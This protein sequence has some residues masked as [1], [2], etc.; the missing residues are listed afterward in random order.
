MR[1]RLFAGAFAAAGLAAVLWGCG[2]SSSSPAPSPSPNPTPAPSPAPSGPT[3]TVNIVA[4]TGS[5]AYQ[6]N[7][8]QASAGDTIAFKNNGGTTHHIVFDDGSV[9]FGSLN[10]GQTSQTVTLKAGSAKFHCTIHS[11]M[12]GAINAPVPDPPPCQTP[13]YCD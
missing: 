11:S 1:S 7:P 13:G 8:V 2:G 5:T 4:D 9:D 6:P 10:P 3:V 12:V